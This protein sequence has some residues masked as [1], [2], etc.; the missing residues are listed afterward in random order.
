MVP[1]W[2]LWYPFGPYGTLLVLMVPFWSLLKAYG[3]LLVL[4]VPFWSLWYPFGPYGTLMVPLWYPYGTLMVPLWYPYGTLIIPPRQPFS[5]K[6]A[7][8]A[9]KRAFVFVRVLS[10]FFEFSLQGHC[11]KHVFLQKG[12]H[13]MS[14][15]LP[16]EVLEVP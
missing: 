6:F 3:T 16:F 5:N 8:F 11:Q 4:M 12:H 13:E 2:S 14:Q 10:W 15:R 1:F 7:R 9:L